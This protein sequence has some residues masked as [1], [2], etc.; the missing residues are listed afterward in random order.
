MIIHVGAF[1]GSLALPD[2]RALLLS[3]DWDIPWPA[4]WY[5]AWVGTTILAFSTVLVYFYFQRNHWKATG[6][7]CAAE[8]EHQTYMVELKKQMQAAD[9]DSRVPIFENIV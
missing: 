7:Q 3:L 6:T 8:L 4:A 5:I 2:L 9:S 1:L